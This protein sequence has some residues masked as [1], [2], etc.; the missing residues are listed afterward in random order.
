MIGWHG[1][2]NGS[3]RGDNDGRGLHLGLANVLTDVP[4]LLYEDLLS[5]KR[6]WDSDE[7]N[8]Q[9]ISRLKTRGQ[10]Q[11][12]KG[13]KRRGPSRSTVEKLLYYI[14]GSSRAS[15][16]YD[17][18]QKSFVLCPARLRTRTCTE[19]HYQYPWSPAR[20]ALHGASAEE[21]RPWYE[22]VLYIKRGSTASPWSV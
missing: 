8:K 10:T 6:A 16:V 11:Q 9:L 4:L 18:M 12:Q 2:S 20:G 22:Y 1:T 5:F 17:K 3:A 7:A 19:P 21:T 13:K 15:L 14:L